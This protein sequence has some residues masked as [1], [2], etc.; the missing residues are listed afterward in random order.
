MHV[1]SVFEPVCGLP[2]GGSCF[3]RSLYAC[4]VSFGTSLWAAKVGHFP[5][6]GYIP[7]MF[8]LGPVFENVAL[9]NTA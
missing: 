3:D 5:T 7:V 4:D 2:M 8:V 9:G 6:G 1:V